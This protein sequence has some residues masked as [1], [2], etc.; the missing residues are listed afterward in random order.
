[1]WGISKTQRRAGKSRVASG[2][3]IRYAGGE[4]ASGLRRLPR[5]VPPAKFRAVISR[6]FEGAQRCNRVCDS[7]R[8]RPDELGMLELW[9]MQATPFRQTPAGMPSRG[10]RPRIK[11]RPL[12]KIGSQAGR[13]LLSIIHPPRCCPN[14]FHKR[15]VC[16]LRAR[17][18]TQS[19]NN[20]LGNC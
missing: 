9:T 1:M 6:A 10:A 13:R 19:S 3:R 16:C 11:R 12:S 15:R 4:S 7:F 20:R 14:Y 5:F 18:V 2:A 17:E 8:I